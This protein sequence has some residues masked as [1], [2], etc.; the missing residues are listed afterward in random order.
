MSHELRYE[1]SVTQVS[2]VQ[3]SRCIGSYSFQYLP[4]RYRYVKVQGTYVP[5]S[6]R[7]KPSCVAGIWFLPLF[8]F[9]VVIVEQFVGT[10][11][12]NTSDEIYDVHM[13]LLLV[14]QF[15]CVILKIVSQTS[16]VKWVI[17]DERCTISFSVFFSDAG[18][19][20]C[21]FEL[22]DPVVDGRFGCV[23]LIPTIYEFGR[24]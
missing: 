11:L 10:Y 1:K 5:L 8:Y 22:F 15:T 21:G 18:I 13:V 9:P 3:R 4:L 14:H 17:F 24:I 2:V 20:T 12:R 7:A 16:M 19:S 23:D 6:L